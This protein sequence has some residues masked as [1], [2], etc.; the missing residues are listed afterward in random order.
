MTLDRTNSYF[1]TDS[2]DGF[3][4]GRG[5]EWDRPPGD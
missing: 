3:Y 4:A 5:A 1:F 2:A